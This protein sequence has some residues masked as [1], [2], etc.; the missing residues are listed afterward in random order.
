MPTKSKG[1]EYKQAIEAVRSKRLSLRQAAEKYGISTTSLHRRV[2]GQVAVSAKKG[3]V[4][5]FT[6]AEEKGIID[7][8]TYKPKHG[9][10][11]SLGELWW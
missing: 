6:P 3:A 11:F 2:A 1:E 4:P 8:I 7:M 10:C 5:Y 9:C